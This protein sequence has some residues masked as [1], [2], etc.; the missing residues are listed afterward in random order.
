MS[1]LAPKLPTPITIPPTSLYTHPTPPL[2]P[3]TPHPLTATPAPPQHLLSTPYT[4]KLGSG[5]WS[6][7]YALTP[8]LAV[9]TPSNPSALPILHAEASILS[10]LTTTLT[11]SPPCIA[12][13]HYYDP[14]TAH[15]YLDHLAA[16]T[17]ESLARAAPATTKT[18][19]QRG[20]P[21][22]GFAQWLFLAERLVAAVRAVHAAG[23]VHG[24]IKWGNVLL[25]PY[26]GGD[27]VWDAY[28]AENPGAALMEP[29]LCD[30]SSAQLGG[31]G[32][33]GGEEV[34]AVTTGFAAP[35]VLRGFLGGGGAPLRGSADVYSVGMTLLAAAL[36]SEVYEGVRHV[37]IYAREGDPVGWV[38]GGERAVR[39]AR[40]GVVEGVVR[41]CFG[42]GE[43]GRVGLEEVAERVK[44]WKGRW[45]EEGRGGGRWGW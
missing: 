28:C 16:G 24:D 13:I 15:L 20:E 10:H 22:L 2:T 33:G 45:W 42:R 35:E 6:T 18:K 36:G 25:R 27:E 12:R 11:A 40:G 21:V 23:V 31:G 39:V 4:A 9:K 17:L 3:L 5:A 29:V 1:P 41:G 7:V 26:A 19:T 14:K 8:Q 30:F 32:G 43:E 34:S 38:R 37:G 44:V